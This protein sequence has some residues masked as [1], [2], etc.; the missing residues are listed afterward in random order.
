MASTEAGAGPAAG[1][2]HPLV[3]AAGEGELP[4]WAVAGAER[5]EHIARV[6]A[7]LDAWARGLRLSEVDALRWRAAGRLHDCL[8]DADPDAL[9]EWLPPDL[10]D[11]PAPLVHGPAAAARFASE[12]VDDAA[13][14]GAVRWHTLGHR[15]LDRLGRAVY[16][17]DF[18]EPERKFEVEWRASLRERMPEELDAVLVEVVAAR[19]RHLVEERR[20]IR[21]ETL[22]FW[23]SLVHRPTRP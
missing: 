3:R 7:L 23:N 1:D 2:V 10:A 19:M 6:V 12:G 9:R 13:V 17:A 22:G 15:E 21:Q 5:R 14:L 18:L 16:L 11:I 4:D 8:R 20:L